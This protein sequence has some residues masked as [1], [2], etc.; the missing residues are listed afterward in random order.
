[1]VIFAITP[2]FNIWLIITS[3]MPPNNQFINQNVSIVCHFN[4]LPSS[5]TPPAVQL[6]SYYGWMAG[7]MRVSEWEEDEKKF[8]TLLRMNFHTR[9]G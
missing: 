2:A 9:Y 6:F 5:S 1:M 8:P 4:F 7:W 3:L